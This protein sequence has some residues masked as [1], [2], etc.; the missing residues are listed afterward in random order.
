MMMI[1]PTDFEAFPTFQVP[2]PHKQ[3]GFGTRDAHCGGLHGVVTSFHCPNIAGL[4]RTPWII[5]D[6]LNLIDFESCDVL[7]VVI[8]WFGFCLHRTR[9]VHPYWYYWYQ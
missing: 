1:K 9:T 8:F 5:L 4:N 2:K 3:N 7:H 6:S